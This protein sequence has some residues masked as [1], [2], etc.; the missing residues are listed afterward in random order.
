MVKTELKKAWYTLNEAAIVLGFERATVYEKARAGSI[1]SGKIGRSVMIPA[2]YVD[3]LIEAGT[4]PP[5]SE[6]SAA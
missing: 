1:P 3:E 5:D 4:T 6:P 2:W